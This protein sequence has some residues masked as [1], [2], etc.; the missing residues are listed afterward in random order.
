[1]RSLLR[2]VLGVVLVIAAALA[3]WQSYRTT[4][5]HRDYVRCQANIN[6]ALI[7]RTRVLTEVAAEER[8][9]QRARDEAL[10]TVL[11]DP[12]LL[13]PVDQRTPA[14]QARVR[15]LYLRYRASVAQLDKA[16]AAGDKA[17]Q[18]NPVPPPPTQVCG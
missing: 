5:A 2:K 17:R 13:K 7:A 15:D 14:D 9:A 1:M 10:D 6:D 4:T 12:S 8:T 16:R 3:V 11:T 18:A